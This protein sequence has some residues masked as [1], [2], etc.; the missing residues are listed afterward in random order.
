VKIESDVIVRSANV[1]TPSKRSRAFVV[2]GGAVQKDGGRR[3]RA[4]F[5]KRGTRKVGG[6]TAKKEGE[7]GPVQVGRTQTRGRFSALRRRQLLVIQ[8]ESPTGSQDRL[9]ERSGQ[10]QKTKQASTVMRKERRESEWGEAKGATWSDA[11]PRHPGS[12][13]GRLSPH[14][15]LAFPLPLTTSPTR[16]LRRR[17]PIFVLLLSLPRM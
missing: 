14:R 17:S 4:T 16:S 15:C 13:T 11:S 5:Q 7:P 1:H 10:K 9:R 8:P 2:S 6:W 3:A 12:R